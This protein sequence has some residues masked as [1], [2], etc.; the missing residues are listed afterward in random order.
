MTHYESADGLVFFPIQ[1]AKRPTYWPL[2]WEENKAACKMF[3]DYLMP[4]GGILLP[5]ELQFDN[6]PIAQRLAWAKFAREETK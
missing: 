2:T 1:E 4:Y 3:C 6:L 5:L